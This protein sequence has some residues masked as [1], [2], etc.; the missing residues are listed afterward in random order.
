MAVDTAKRPSP[1]VLKSS[2]PS[3][4]ESFAA[5]RAAIVKA[6]SLDQK[7]QELIVL[8]GFVVARQESGFKSH[9]RRALDHGAAPEDVKTAVVVN[10]GATAS[11]EL[12]GDALR[13]VDEVLAERASG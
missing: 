1:V 10:L 6:G 2:F 13:W 12:V 4:A 3:V 8:A 7:L 9:A 5:L 11:I